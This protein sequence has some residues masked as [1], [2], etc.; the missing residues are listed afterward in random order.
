MDWEKVAGV[1]TGGLFGFI[2]QERNNQFNA[3]QAREQREWEERMSNT[4]Y[5][6]AVSDMQQ[7]GLNPA[8]MYGQAGSSGASTPSG[9][10]ASSSGFNAIA[11]ALSIAK[12]G[13]E[14]RGMHLENQGRELSNSYQSLVNFYYP[15]VQ[16]ASIKN[17]YKELDVKDADINN[18]NADTNLK[19][20]QRI[21]NELESEW[22]P[23]LA[24]AQS[25]QARASA[26]RD[27]AEAAISKWEKELGYRLGNNELLT[28]ATG[29]LGMFGLTPKEVGEVIKPK[30][31]PTPHT[32]TVPDSNGDPETIY[33]TGI[34]MVD[35]WL[36]RMNNKADARAQKRLARRSK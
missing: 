12:L 19:E 21:L 34:P 28:L 32:E 16:D 29:L 17:L 3:Q 9:A 1:A 18:K 7:A 14:L 31:T 36:Q 24:E 22:R 5:Q 13:E 15:S 30:L 23:K 33:K 20:S 6:R 27:L 26:A 8:L 10:S 4:A 2:Q 11:D 25:E 35:N